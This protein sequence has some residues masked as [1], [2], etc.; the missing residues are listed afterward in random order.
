MLPQ[1][2]GGN[3]AKITKERSFRDWKWSLATL[4]PVSSLTEEN[5]M[6][7]TLG[8]KGKRKYTVV[9]EEREG[10]NTFPPACDVDANSSSPSAATLP[11]WWMAITRANFHPPQNLPNVVEGNAGAKAAAFQLE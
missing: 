9:F 5:S 7:K 1:L 8:S 3:D 2:S 11:A 10:E 6:A 4:L